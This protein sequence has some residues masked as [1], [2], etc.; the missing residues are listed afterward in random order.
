MQALR[1]YL[2]EREFLRTH[3]GLHEGAGPQPC[4]H[5][6]TTERWQLTF[7][8]GSFNT[9]WSA[10]SITSTTLQHQRPHERQRPR[11]SIPKPPRP[12]QIFTTIIIIITIYKTSIC[13]RVSLRNRTQQA[14]HNII[15]ITASIRANERISPFPTPRPQHQEV[16]K[17]DFR[18][19]VNLR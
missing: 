7:W 4:Q 3:T 13:L 18:V 12:G 1:I 15:T 17:T 6:S 19:V 14:I 8:S 5:P 2:D 11:R 16:L 9:V 10:P